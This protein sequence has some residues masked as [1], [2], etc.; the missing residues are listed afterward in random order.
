MEVFQA[1]RYDHCRH[2]AASD[3]RREYLVIGLQRA[4]CSCAVHAIYKKVDAIF[5]VEASEECS[6]VL[7]SLG[8]RHCAL[9][10]L[11]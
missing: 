4:D 9:E 5:L 3:D 1:R 7:F 6:Q 10:A 11:V 8:S 2:L